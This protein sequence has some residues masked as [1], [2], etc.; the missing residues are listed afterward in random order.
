MSLTTGRSQLGS[1]FKSLKQEWEATENVWRDLVRKEFA[2]EHWEPL[3]ARLSSVLTA[4]DRFDEALG[5]MK[6]ECE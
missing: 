4:M 3:S 5:Q 6:Q 1:A 2:D